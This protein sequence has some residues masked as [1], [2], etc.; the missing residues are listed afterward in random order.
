[1][2]KKNEIMY[3]LFTL[4]LTLLLLASY[5]QNSSIISMSKQIDKLTEENRGYK[6]DLNKLTK[7]VNELNTIVE[8]YTN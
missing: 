6:D 1:M 3:V 5:S 4:V 2:L 8:E 7:K